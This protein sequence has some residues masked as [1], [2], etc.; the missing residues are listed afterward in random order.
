MRD[1]FARR[2]REIGSHARWLRRDCRGQELV[3]Y[4]LLAGFVAILIGAA[5]PTRIVPTLSD[6]FTKLST[7]IG[8][9]A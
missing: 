8:K 7:V 4:A 6:I 2:L 3:E 1:S 9:F 5:V